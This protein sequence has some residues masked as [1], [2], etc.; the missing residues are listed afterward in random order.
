[1]ATWLEPMFYNV[2]TVPRSCWLNLSR[3]DLKESAEACALCALILREAQETP[4][5][6]APSSGTIVRLHQDCLVSTLALEVCCIDEGKQARLKVAFDKGMRAVVAVTRELG[7][8]FLWVDALC[9]MQDDRDDWLREA[10]RMAS[11]YRDVLATLCADWGPDCD[12]GLFDSRAF[13]GGQDGALR[14]PWPLEPG[15]GGEAAS[16]QPPVTLQVFR[17]PPD[18]QQEVGHCALSRRGWAFQERA[19]SGRLVHFGSEVRYWECKQACVCEDMAF[20]L[21]DVQHQ[22]Q[23]VTDMLSTPT[24][25]EHRFTHL[26]WVLTISDYSNRLLTDPNDIFPALEGVASAF[27]SS[28]MLGKYVCGLWDGELLWHLL[29][30]AKRPKYGGPGTRHTWA[31]PY[32]APS[33]SWAGI[34]G[35]V[36][37]TVLFNR[38]YSRL[39]ELEVKAVTIDTPRARVGL[40]RCERQLW[41]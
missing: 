13:V 11:V 18:F 40:G 17:V 12:Y 4:S 5:T 14:H 29:W 31:R 28:G 24:E 22:V 37:N 10:A 7:V 26:R 33:W 19:L 41:R 9:I 34:H 25:L 6:P 32:R 30:S 23:H 15:G 1:M 36:A 38:E 35:P 8:R 3:A 20:G 2:R 16:E 27:G 39:R 21:I